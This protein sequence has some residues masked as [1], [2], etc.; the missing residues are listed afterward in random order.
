MGKKAAMT[1]DKCSSKREIKVNATNQKHCKRNEGSL[2][3]AHKSIRHYQVKTQE[4]GR[5]MNKNLSYANAK[6]KWNATWNIMFK[7]CRKIINGKI[8]V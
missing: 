8:C 4:A 6:R 2:S 5:F 7:D 1:T 3:L